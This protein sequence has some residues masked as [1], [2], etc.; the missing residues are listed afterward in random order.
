M[1]KGEN[2]NSMKS[3]ITIFALAAASLAV[4]GCQRSLLSSVQELKPRSSPVQVGEL[5]PDFTLED[6][7][8]QKTTLSAARGSMPTVLVFYRGDW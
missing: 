1:D 5:A 7:N 2:R 8:G 3:L 6:H 4:A